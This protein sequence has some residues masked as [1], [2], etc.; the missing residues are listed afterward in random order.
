MVIQQIWFSVLGS[1]EY[2]NYSTGLASFMVCD[3]YGAHHCGRAHGL[4]A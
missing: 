2:W 3:T 4:L 1:S